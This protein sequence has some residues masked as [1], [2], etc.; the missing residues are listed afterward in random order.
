MTEQQQQPEAVIAVKHE[1]CG[2]C[3]IMIWFILFVI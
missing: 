1:D 3:G 2:G